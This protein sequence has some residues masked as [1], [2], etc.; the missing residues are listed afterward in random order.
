MR[1]CVNKSRAG[2][3]E[4][5]RPAGL[6]RCGQRGPGVVVLMDTFLIRAR[7]QGVRRSTRTGVRTMP[8]DAVPGIDDLPRLGRWLR[9]NG[10]LPVAA[11]P[12]VRLI[13]GGRS[14]LTYLVDGR[15]AAGPDAP[16]LVL[17]RPPLG[18]VLPTAH[19]MGRE[20]H[21]RR[22]LHEI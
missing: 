13:A 3:P 22:A 8:D 20:N 5:S 21:A 9:D 15:A 10:I 17:R 18:P 19:D 12:E 14:N 4:N 7:P 6:P 11:P 2:S 16:L 1:Q